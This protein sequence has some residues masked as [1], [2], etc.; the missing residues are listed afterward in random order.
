MRLGSYPTRIADANPPYNLEAVYPEKGT[1]L[2][3]RPPFVTDGGN[4]TSRGKHDLTLADMLL[5]G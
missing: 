2:I 3:S 4:T 5:S 1:R